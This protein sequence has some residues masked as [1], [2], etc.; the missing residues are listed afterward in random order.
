MSGITIGAIAVLVI[1]LGIAGYTLK[2]LYEEVGELEQANAQLEQS[3]SEEVD[4]NAELQTEIQRRD[5]AVLA[6]KR[7]RERAES[8]ADSIRSD[9]DKALKDDPWTRK[10]VPAAVVNSLQAGARADQD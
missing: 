1:L 10:P 6:A 3:L 8:E 4:E 5:N 9:R 7:A 2:N